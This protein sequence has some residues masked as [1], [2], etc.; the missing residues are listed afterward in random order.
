M[1]YI[2][3]NI[4]L[5]AATLGLSLWLGGCSADLLPQTAK[6]SQE[7]ST[8]GSA[9]PSISADTKEEMPNPFG[10][11]HAKPSGG[12][13]VI[14]QPTKADILAVGPLPEMSWGNANAPV[15]IVK[16]ASLT[17]Q[18]CKRF[19]A[20]TFPE[21]KRAYI[22]TGKVRFIL[23]EFPI[24]RTSGMATITLRCAPPD[25]Y[26]EL[27]GK[28]LNQQTAWVSQ[29]VRL[30]PIFAVAQQVGMTRA[31]FDACRENQGMIEGLKW[32]KDRGRKLGIIGT[33]NFFVGDKLVK[34]VLT[35]AEIRAL[36]EPQLQSGSPA[37]AAAQPQ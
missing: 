21:L 3:R 4:V 15:T 29:D 16:Y 28:F 27:Y 13:E 30:D 20:E 19:H 8:A 22:D 7:A 23:R 11:P 34:S 12:R 17:C 33:P 37:S 2:R 1:I 32:I 9:Y 14:E 5:S 26:L 31:Q 6:L 10:D 24:G 18:H 35:M 25:K 36:V